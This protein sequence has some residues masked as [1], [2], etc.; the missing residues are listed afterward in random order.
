MARVF[1]LKLNQIGHSGA[2]LRPF[3]ADHVCQYSVRISLR[4]S[5]KYM[6]FAAFVFRSTSKE[7]GELLGERQF[8]D[9][10]ADG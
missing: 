7:L 6:V 4:V 8:G 9:P 2:P 5:L 1:S 10:T 3:S